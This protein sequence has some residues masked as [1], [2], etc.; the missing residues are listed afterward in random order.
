M[1]NAYTE[2]LARQER[3]AEARRQRAVSSDEAR[4]LE[5]EDAARRM[6][7]LSMIAA[8][9]PEELAAAEALAT[10]QRNQIEGAVIDSVIE[11]LGQ[12][13]RIM[14]GLNDNDRLAV[15]LLPSSYLNPVVSWSRAT[16]RDQEFIISVRYGDVLDLAEGDLSEDDFGARVRIERRLGQ[17]RDQ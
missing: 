8:A 5:D 3:E 10:D 9:T 13:G 2:Y 1:Q 14:H 15:V 17:Q 12:Y 6:G 4:P 16:Q 11:T 7:S